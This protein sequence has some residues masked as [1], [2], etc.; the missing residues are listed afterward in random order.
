MH[1]SRPEVK[2]GFKSFLLLGTLY[3][4]VLDIIANDSFCT[5]REAATFASKVGVIKE[6][7]TDW[8][9]LIAV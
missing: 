5:K 9:Y 4:L 6:K 2:H 3:E 7:S 8:R 1:R